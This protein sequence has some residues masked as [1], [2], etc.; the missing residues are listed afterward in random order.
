MQ[1]TIGKVAERVGLTTY[2]LRYYEKEGLLPHIQKDA[3]GNRYYSE[4]DIFW[5]ELIKCLKDTGMPIAAIKHIVELSLQGEDT[6]PKRKEILL[7]HKES[8]EKQMMLLQQSMDK[9]D[10]KIA[11]YNGEH[12]ACSEK[13]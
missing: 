1:Y 7:S 4:D 6:V 12:T 9:I 3:K 11:W 5:I 13:E 2:T 10:K 8:L